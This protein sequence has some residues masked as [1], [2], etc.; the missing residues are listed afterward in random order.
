MSQIKLKLHAYL[1]RAWPWSSF[2]SSSPATC[3]F[4]YMFALYNHSLTSWPHMRCSVCPNTPSPIST[5]SLLK[6]QLRPR[7]L[8]EAF[9]VR[10]PQPCPRFPCHCSSQSGLNLP[11][12]SVPTLWSSLMFSI[13]PTRD[14]S[15]LSSRASPLSRSYLQVYSTSSWAVCPLF[16]PP[17]PLFTPSRLCALGAGLVSA[18]SCVGLW[19]VP[20]GDWKTR[21]E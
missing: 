3:P 13:A 8:P 1:S 20:A 18:A 17:M 16:V 2:P 14:A 7:F 5:Y 11:L 6:T 4:H 19:E 10:A 15:L 9:E 21:R 12:F